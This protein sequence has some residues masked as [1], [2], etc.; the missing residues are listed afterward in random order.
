[1][2]VKTVESTAEVDVVLKSNLKKAK[3]TLRLAPLSFEVKPVQ[4]TADFQV[5]LLLI[6]AKLAVSS[7]RTVTE[8]SICQ[9]TNKTPSSKYI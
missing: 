9:R 5:V 1:M 8:S 6:E 7:C 3:Q 4:S 2:E